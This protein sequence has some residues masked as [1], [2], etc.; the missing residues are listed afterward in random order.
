MATTYS[1]A[2]LQR[3]ATILARAEREQNAIDNA[4]IAAVKRAA[5]TLPVGPT[6]GTR[7]AVK[8]TPL[9]RPATNGQQRRINRAEIALGYRVSPRS[10]LGSIADAKKIWAGL[11]LDAKLAGIRLDVR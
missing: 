4:R 11:K 10:V 5:T 7:Q 3:C 2:T 6:P 9:A 8:T 1:P